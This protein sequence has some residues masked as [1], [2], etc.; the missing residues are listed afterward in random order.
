MSHNIFANIL[1]GGKGSQVFLKSSFL[2]SVEDSEIFGNSK[3]VLIHS[4]TYCGFLNCFTL[5][6]H[7]KREEQPFLGLLYPFPKNDDSTCAT[8]DVNF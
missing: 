5:M 8:Q 3:T 1:I 7:K 4:H 2:K 6:P